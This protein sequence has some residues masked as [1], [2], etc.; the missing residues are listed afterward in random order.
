MPQKESVKA[1]TIS[2]SQYENVIASERTRER[3][4]PLFWRGDCFAKSARNDILRFEISDQ[5]SQKVFLT[6][7]G[8]SLRSKRQF[9]WFTNLL[10]ER[11]RPGS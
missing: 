4:N 8:F 9:G 1:L 6:A 5:V 3:S 7:Q 2:N 11:G 10:R